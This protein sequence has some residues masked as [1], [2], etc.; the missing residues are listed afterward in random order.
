MAGMSEER[1]ALQSAKFKQA[2][3]TAKELA[4]KYG[5]K[6]YQY[7]LVKGENVLKEENKLEEIMVNPEDLPTLIWDDWHLEYPALYRDLEKESK[8]MSSSK[9]WI[10]MNIRD[11]DYDI[12]LSKYRLWK[13]SKNFNTNTI[14]R[15]LHDKWENINGKEVIYIED[16]NI[17]VYKELYKK[18]GY[19]I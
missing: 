5:G 11:D 4:K 13:P 19:T 2:W 7:F 6:A 9:S 3:Q 17:L 1:R 12:L 10:Q 18:A 16:W 14:L 8:R 15:E